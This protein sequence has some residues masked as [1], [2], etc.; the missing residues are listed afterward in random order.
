MEIGGTGAEE[1]MAQVPVGMGT[2]VRRSMWKPSR[3]L[4]PV[5]FMVLPEPLVVAD[6]PS[7]QVPEIDLVFFNAISEALKP[8]EWAEVPLA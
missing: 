7:W 6:R 2:G 5:Q 1:P 3:P 4:L 8:A